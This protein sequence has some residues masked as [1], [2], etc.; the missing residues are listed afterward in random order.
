MLW[1]RAA[2]TVPLGGSMLR[3]MTIEVTDAA[4]VDNAATATAAS[5]GAI[6]GVIRAIFIDYTTLAVT[7]TDV[8]IAGDTGEAQDL[9]IITVTDIGTD[10][11]KFPGHAVVNTSNSAIS[12]EAMPIYIDNQVVVT[13]TGARTDDDLDVI[14]I[15]EQLH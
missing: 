13:V 8:V 10:T 2:E 11:W 7:T 3:R 5:D 9:P 15:Y 1:E 12:N 6:S 4:G 14:I